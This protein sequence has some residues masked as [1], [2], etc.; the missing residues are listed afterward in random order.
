MRF[1][2][3]A[4][5]GDLEGLDCLLSRRQ[6][7]KVDVTWVDTN[8][9]TALHLCVAYGH[10]HC[11]GRLVRARIPVDAVDQHTGA[12][13]LMVAAEMGDVESLNALV[14]RGASMDARDIFGATPLIYAASNYQPHFVH[15]L[16]ARYRPRSATLAYVQ[17]ADRAARTAMHHALYNYDVKSATVLIAFGAR[18]DQPVMD[19]ED[20][21]W[22][23]ALIHAAELNNL[24]C[25]TYCIEKHASVSCTPNGDGKTPLMFAAF[26]GADAC[27][28]ALCRCDGVD[29][30]GQDAGGSSAL[31]HAILGGSVESIH[32]L[33]LYGAD[34]LR[35][36]K[37]GRNALLMLA[38]R[39]LTSMRALELLMEYG[40][41][42]EDTDPCGRSA[43]H[44]AA[45][46]G[47][48]H[49]V[50]ALVLRFRADCT[51]TCECGSNAVMYAAMANSAPIIEHLARIC[52]VDIN[53]P[54]AIGKTPLMHACEWGRNDAIAML[55][56]LGADVHAA[57]WQGKTGL[58]MVR[59]AYG[60]GSTSERV[61]VASLVAREQA[62][63]MEAV[64]AVSV[65]VNEL[66]AGGGPRHPEGPCL[67]SSKKDGV[68]PERADCEMMI[69]AHRPDQEQAQAQ[70][71][72]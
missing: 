44:Y 31:F 14:Q 10:H 8:G 17:A 42:V 29:V 25:M 36:D 45:M 54:N 11:I 7:P 2:F 57:D 58:D 6:S 46:G 64:R 55:I 47:H 26:A 34:P 12:T 28:D 33:L 63:V 3:A 69:P 70:A 60:R 18:V 48:M 4:E 66:G 27:V 41:H 15:R 39:G 37:A 32:I 52:D 35:V 13:P 72:T 67:V 16:L 43:L 71:G 23:T 20:G 5:S 62:C 50:R 53:M 21:Q 68:A 51:A 9:R 49:L 40:A 65:A 59:Y 24:E 38:R 1:L 61:F 56:S 30:N 22:K 19:V